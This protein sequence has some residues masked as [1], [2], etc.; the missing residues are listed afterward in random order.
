MNRRRP[1][2]ALSLG[3][4]GLHS[5]VS[6]MASVSP[7]PWGSGLVLV[8]DGVEHPVSLAHA[9][10]VPGATVLGGIST[11]EHLLAALLG[12]G[13]TDARIAVAGPELPGLDGSAAPWCAALV[14]VGAEEEQPLAP[15]RIRRAWRHEGH[16]GAV[17]LAP[18]DTLR[19]SVAVDYPE[20]GLRGEAAWSPGQD[21]CTQV[22]PAR[23]F[24]LAWQVDALRAAGRGRGA[25]LDNTVVL[26]PEGPLNP[27]GTRFADGPV[28]HRLLDAL[29]DLALLGLA[30][31][32]HLRVIRGSHRLHQ[33]ALRAALRA[34]IID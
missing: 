4:A 22:A 9:A 24:A 5:G 28:R 6:C 11:P 7:G 27:G 32:G 13:L 12:P 8:R 3:G 18:S 2:T 1:A 20:V 31:T 17:V 33:E 25:D 30:L 19:V 14:A 26:G 21:F 10:A 16:G 23:T 15:L 29:G 34:G